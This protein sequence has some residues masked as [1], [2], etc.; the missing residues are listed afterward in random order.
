VFYL[1]KKFGYLSL[2]V[3]LG[4]SLFTTAHANEVYDVNK[5]DQLIKD[6]S[7][8]NDQRGGMWWHQTLSMTTHIVES[9]YRGKTEKDMEIAKQLDELNRMYM[10]FVNDVKRIPDDAAYSP[11][12]GYSSRALGIITSIAKEMD[13]YDDVT[14]NDLGL[15]RYLHKRASEYRLDVF[16]TKE[17]SLEYYKL[18]NH[19]LHKYVASGGSFYDVAQVWK[20]YQL[21]SYEFENADIAI[22]DSLLELSMKQTSDP[23]TKAYSFLDYLE[24][25]P[26]SVKSPKINEHLRNVLLAMNQQSSDYR[27]IFSYL[28]KISYMKNAAPD[29]L[30]KAPLTMMYQLFSTRIQD[31]A[32]VINQDESYGFILNLPSLKTDDVNLAKTLAEVLRKRFGT[33]HDFDAYHKKILDEVLQ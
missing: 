11:I 20:S 22:L 21:I 31:I 1:L 7:S 2:V 10:Q 33:N 12:G 32:K 5:V 30:D 23:N 16:A 17:E 6:T 3:Y 28:E 13:K 18:L 19:L 25:L 26:T 9:Y 14:S 24:L 8:R 15:L 4:T 29:Y 27:E